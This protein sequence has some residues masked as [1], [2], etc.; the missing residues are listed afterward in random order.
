MQN[1]PNILPSERAEAEDPSRLPPQIN[2]EK[3]FDADIGLSPRSGPSPIAGEVAVLDECPLPASPVEKTTE[4]DS[5]KDCSDEK[6]PLDGDKKHQRTDSASSVIMSF[7]LPPSREPELQVKILGRLPIRD[8]APVEISVEP[9]STTQV[10]GQ[11][12]VEP[13]QVPAHPPVTEPM[14]LELASPSPD[15]DTGASES[16]DPETPPEQE[17]SNFPSQRPAS[18]DLNEV[19]QKVSGCMRRDRAEESDIGQSRVVIFRS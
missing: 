11:L 1:I 18:P 2:R 12:L 4:G 10:I 6:L 7:P 15:E 3:W 17:L 14:E 13:V 19:M 9:E 8:N 16:E 5:T